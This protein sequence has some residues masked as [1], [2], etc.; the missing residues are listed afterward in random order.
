[1]DTFL[2]AGLSASVLIIFGFC[3]FTLHYI[4]RYKAELPKL[5]LIDKIEALEA[6][7]DEVESQLE[8]LREKK[9]QAETVIEDAKR[10]RE[11][12]ASNEAECQRLRNDLLNLQQESE[13]LERLREEAA[14]LSSQIADSESRKL[15]NEALAA[16]LESQV[17]TLNEELSNLNDLR[18]ELHELESRLPSLKSEK[19]DLELKIDTL[20]G[21][22]KGLEEEWR[23]L[24]EKINTGRG[25]LAELEGNVKSLEASYERLKADIEEK[26]KSFEAE[27]V[28]HNEHLAS[29]KTDIRGAGGLDENDSKLDDLWKSDFKPDENLDTSSTEIERLERLTTTLRN[30]GVRIATR[31]IYSFHTALKTQSISPL[32]VLAGISGTGKSLL[33]KLYSDCMG[34]K[35]LNMAV[36]PGWN[37]P[38]D[39]FGF[40]NYIE[41][42]Y[43]GTPLARAMVQFDEYLPEK[44]W[45]MSEDFHR[46]NDQVLLVLLDEMNLARIEY[47]F[48]ELLSRL[49][50]RRLI[51]E[52]DKKKRSEV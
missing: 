2:Y 4:S 33:P 19:S 29:L 39:M 25:E 45:G 40:Y 13:Q 15:E 17:R 44:Y 18:S 5:K 28:S 51:N 26:R 35:F 8:E 12:M 42:K 32:T 46:M 9:F 52:D 16:Q 49:E 41:Q 24:Q 30:A 14:D 50:L 7:R 3:A 21:D 27:I 48:S 11:E 20:R 43:K 31:T 47:Y 23:E 6:Q 37:S 22:L 1:M 36:Q 34:I 38:Q 10:R